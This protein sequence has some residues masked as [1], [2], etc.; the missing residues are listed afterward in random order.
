[1]GQALF[2][3]Q[4]R[5]ELRVFNR[6]RA[7][8]HR[9]TALEALFDVFNG[10]LV[11]LLRGL[12][13]TVQLIISVA[14]TVGRYHHRLQT[15][16]FLKLVRLGV[17]RSRHPG[18]LGIKTEIVL[19]G[20]GRHGLVL[21]LNGHPFLGFNGLVQTFAPTPARHQSTRELIHNRDL[22]A[23][24]HIVLIFEIQMMCSEGRIQVVHQADV[25]RIIKRCACR[26]EVRLR[27]K[28]LSV[29]MTHLGQKHLPRFLIQGEVSRRDDAFSR[30]GVLLTNLA[31]QLG[32]NRIHGNVDRRVVLGLT[33]DDQRRSRLVNQNRIHL[34]H[35][36]VIEPSLHAVLCLIDH[37]VPEVVKAVLVVGAVG[38]VTAVSRLLVGSGQLGQID[39]HAQ[40]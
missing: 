33:T 2:G 26:Q 16:N 25:G 8:Q 31:D 32:H 35:D 1:M 10:R 22:T 38:D 3:Q 37:V 15:I 5:D 39:P 34:V 12:V 40:S 19:K 14:R 18:Q 11:L 21:G 36:G 17:C 4:L 28:S 7:H 23:L 20:D 6:G 27:E 9:L 29:F 24:A 30:S 13:N